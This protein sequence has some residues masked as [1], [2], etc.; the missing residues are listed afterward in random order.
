MALFILERC[1]ITSRSSS[2][3]S[4]VAGIQFSGTDIGAGGGMLLD[5]RNMIPSALLTRT[6]VFG[7]ES[8]KGERRSWA[9]KH[10]AET[11]ILGVGNGLSTAFTRRVPYGVARGARIAI[12]KTQYKTGRL[13][14]TVST[15]YS[16]SSVL[17]NESIA[18][19][20][21]LL[22]IRCSCFGRSLL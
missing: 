19:L 11:F 20:L 17:V 15:R 10:T 6:F 22:F 3:A 12:G 14:R 18:C 8:G 7:V 5:R 21:Q 1:D 2:S 16:M 4:Y 9:A 13:G